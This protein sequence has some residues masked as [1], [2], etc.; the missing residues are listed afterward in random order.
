MIQSQRVSLLA[1]LLTFKQLNVRK[2]AVSG[3]SCQL[4][5]FVVADFIGTDKCSDTHGAWTCGSCAPQVATEVTSSAM[6]TRIESPSF[7]ALKNV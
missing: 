6:L 4:A 2:L 3:C 5:R 7:R 1:L